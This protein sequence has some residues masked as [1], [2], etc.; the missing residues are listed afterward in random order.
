MS[1][2][3]WGIFVIS[4]GV[5][6]ILFIIL[7][8]DITNSYEHNSH[9]LKEV[10]E[11]AMFDSIDYAVYRDEGRVVI[12]KEKFTENFI[13]RFSENASLSNEYKVSIYD[14][15]ESPPKVSLKVTNTINSKSITSTLG[16]EETV[17]FTITNRIDA[18]LETPY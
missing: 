15:N 4:L 11:A 6:G 16:K 12:N 10:T 2:S 7:F 13:R 3:F 17:D 9:L 5:A 18:I 1:R 14:I 8:Q